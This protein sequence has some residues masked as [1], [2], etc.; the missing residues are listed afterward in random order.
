M[1]IVRD[2]LETWLAVRDSVPWQ[3]LGGTVE[4]VT[5]RRDGIAVFVD[6]VVRQRDPARADTLLKAL[7]GVRAAK[8]A[9]LS[10]ELMA[11]WLGE[12]AEFRTTPAFAKGGRE[13]YGLDET[14]PR[15]FRECLA[16]SHD[17]AVPLAARAARVYL[18]VCFF[19]PFPDG[20]ARAAMLAFAH[21]LVRD[22]VT[23]G[24]A[25]P[26]LLVARRADDRAGTLALVKLVEVLIGRLPARGTEHVAHALA[27]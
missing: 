23:V 6:T 7:A 12:R 13:R 14:T 15:R 24:Q 9:E 20:N 8:D 11:R 25:G 1:P 18:D 16:E 4:P 22:G 3:T 27:P 5:G 2:D 21:L 26:L 19:H 17:P 10:F